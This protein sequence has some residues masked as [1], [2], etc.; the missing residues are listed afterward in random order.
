MGHQ[1]EES[2]SIETQHRGTKRWVPEAD[3][4]RK[5]LE[6]VLAFAYGMQMG[7]LRRIADELTRGSGPARIDQ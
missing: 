3:P 2:L 7:H 6:R 5:N 1:T 4:D